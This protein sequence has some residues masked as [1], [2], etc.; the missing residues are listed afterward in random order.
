MTRVIYFDYL[1]CVTFLS[2]Y[3][4]S[5]NIRISTELEILAA[6]F[7]FVNF[8]YKH[9]FC[10]LLFSKPVYPIDHAMYRSSKLQIPKLDSHKT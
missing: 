3:Y 2:S 5:I 7:H 1:I 6:I 8:L 9:L 10:V 4:I